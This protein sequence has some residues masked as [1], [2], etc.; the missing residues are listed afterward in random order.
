MVS[1]Q[2]E[3]HDKDNRAESYRLCDYTVTGEVSNTE[4]KRDIL[5]ACILKSGEE[6]VCS[7][8]N[9][10]RRSIALIKLKW[11]STQV[12]LMQ[13]APDMAPDDEEFPWVITQGRHWNKPY[14]IWLSE[15]GKSHTT[16][17]VGREVYEG[18]RKN[19]DQPWNIF[20]NMRINSPDYEAWLLL[21]NMRDRR[22]VW[23]GVHLHRL[24]KSAL[25]STQPFFTIRDGKPDAWPYCEQ[26]NS[27]VNPADRQ[28]NLFTI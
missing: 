4:M 18:L 13:R 6:D 25:S 28:L 9:S 11:G 14:L 19:P 2:V 8:Q 10:R 16:H 3:R 17:L 20:N 7:Y 23:V 27:N 1:M 26:E 21:G 22:N 15:Q 12:S 5:D 24:K